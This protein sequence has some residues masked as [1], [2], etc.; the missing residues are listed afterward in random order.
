[1]CI[2]A[3]IKQATNFTLVAPLG[4]LPFYAT[5]WYRSDRG[6]ASRA[7]TVLFENRQIATPKKCISPRGFVLN[8]SLKPLR[9]KKDN[10]DTRD[11]WD[12]GQERHFAARA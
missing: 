12:T 4:H 1:M 7:L 10:G 6:W 2:A 3:Y 8:S 9:D 5:L 11:R